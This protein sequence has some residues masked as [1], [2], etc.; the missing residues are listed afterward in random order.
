MLEASRRNNIGLNSE[1]L[2][3]KSPS[4]NFFG[5]TITDQGL[6]PASE[7]LEAIRNLKTPTNSKELLTALGM[8]TYLNRF[9]AKLADLTAPLR[10][11]TKKDVH[12]HWEKQY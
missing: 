9:S 4:V 12:F 10:E 1:K 5:H 8:I 7:K 11:L 3:F 2:Q 6:E